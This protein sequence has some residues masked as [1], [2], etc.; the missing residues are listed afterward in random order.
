MLLKKVLASLQPTPQS[1]TLSHAQ[2][3]DRMFDLVNAEGG[4]GECRCRG[5]DDQCCVGLESSPGLA[6]RCQPELTA[7]GGL[8]GC[9]YSPSPY[10]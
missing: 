10:L 5:H 9:C 4:R 2:P 1:P 8:N 6:H 7:S 3:L